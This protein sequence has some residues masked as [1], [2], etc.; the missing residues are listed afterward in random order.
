MY[1]YND[2][3][4]S[5]KRKMPLLTLTCTNLKTFCPTLSTHLTDDEPCTP[6]AC[7]RRCAAVDDGVW[8]AELA[9]FSFFILNSYSG[10][11]ETISDIRKS[12][13]DIHNTV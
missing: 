13:L 11:R 10:Y 9:L 3:C 2:L 5:F 8:Q 6:H 12:I 1:M 4:F 7:T